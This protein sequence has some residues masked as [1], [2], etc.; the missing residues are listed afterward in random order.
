MS[1]RLENQFMRIGELAEQTDC[2]VETVRYYEQQ[3]LLPKPARSAG[4]FR[5]YGRTHVERLSFIRHCRS[6]DMTLE[7]IR[8]LLCFRDAPERNCAD[9]NR[10]LD[11]HIGHVAER[12]A[13]MRRLETQ[14][15]ALRRRCQEAQG[16]KDCG[17]L[18]E[19][20]NYSA[21]ANIHGGHVHGVNERSHDESGSGRVRR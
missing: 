16:T 1:S 19:L 18:N 10:L 2:Q 13:D 3:G 5:I 11:E 7:E 6:L 15:R 12:I 21:R 14:L 17:I 8:A 20:A 9:V 4:N